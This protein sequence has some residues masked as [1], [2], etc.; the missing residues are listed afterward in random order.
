MLRTGK[1]QPPSSSQVHTG[2]RLRSASAQ[3]SRDGSFSL[4]CRRRA[5]EERGDFVD[6][7]AAE[8]TELDD[9][10]EPRLLDGQQ[11]ERAQLAMQL[12][13]QIRTKAVEAAQT[14]FQT[15]V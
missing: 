12:A 8:E 6:V 14:L 3:P 5:A 7:Q 13:S 9:A 11:V 15:Q 10:R 2:P 1:I 4:G